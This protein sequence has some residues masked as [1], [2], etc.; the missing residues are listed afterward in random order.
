[1]NRPNTVV[2]DPR[3]NCWLSFGAPKRVLSSSL[4]ADVIPILS[5]VQ[6]AAARGRVWSIGWLSYDA[7]PAFDAGLEVRGGSEVPLVWFGQY[8][9]P[10]LVDQLPAPNQ[11]G[12][13]EWQALMSEREYVAAFSAVHEHI[14]RGDSYQ[15]N[16]SFRMQARGV[17]DAYAMFHSMVSQQAGRYSFFIDAG[18]FAVCSASPELFFELSAGNVVCRPMKGTAKRGSAESSDEASIRGLTASEKEKA[19]NV[20]IVDMVRNDLSR[21]ADSG[22]VRVSSLFTVER[23]PRV[24][25]MVSEVRALTT[26]SLTEI[27]KATFPSASITGAP[28][29]S[30]MRII[31]RCENSPRGVYTGSLGIVTPED[32]SWFNVA[33]RTAVVNQNTNVAEYGV[34][35]GIVWDSRA[36]HEYN[37]CALKAHVIQPLRARPGLFE[38]LLW[39]GEKGYWLLDHHIERLTASAR[40]FGYA[41][42]A[43]EVKG[44]LLEAVKARTSSESRL[45]VRLVVDPLGAI[46]TEVSLLP[47]TSKPYKVSLAREPID[48]TDIRLFHKSMDRSLYDTAT[49]VVA[50][51]DD[52]LLWNERGE[53]TESRIANV[54]VSV[55]GTLHTP[56]V[57][58]GLLPG[59]LRRELLERGE[60][61]EQVITIDDLRRADSV[62]LANSLR[63]MWLVEVVG[64]LHSQEA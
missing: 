23:F 58:S 47:V 42:N 13:F 61:V 29:H 31:N 60:V 38:T 30:T 26:A 49:P 59:C 48:S 56:P 46:T 44:R 36:A 55:G 37:E 3:H 53:V 2:F 45:R 18:Q 20:M 43:E 17:G 14:S 21:I 9:A 5:E 12:A 32:R 51:V 4:V 15:V 28:K 27:L 50:G 41:C 35:S 6:D 1:M 62:Y 11:V 19:E 25:Q 16:L 33:I 63:G 64:E 57:S 7:A 39:D 22:S 8:D 40:C 54:L 34:G 52:V 24:F 10:T